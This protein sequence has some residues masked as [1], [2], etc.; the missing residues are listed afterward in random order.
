MAW[1]ITSSNIIVDVD[2]VFR[3]ESQIG[4][5]IELSE[6]LIK[7]LRQMKYYG[8]EPQH[9]QGLN[10]AE[11]FPCIRFL[12]TKVLETREETGDLVRRFSE[13]Q[14]KKNYELP[15]DS[16][17]REDKNNAI[18]YLDSVAEDYKPKRKF[19]QAGVGERD[20]ES[21]RVQATILEYG[22]QQK[23]TVVSAQEHDN[24]EAKERAAAIAE[25]LKESGITL[26]DIEAEEA[27]ISEIMRNLGKV[28]G[29]A[30]KVSSST[31]SNIVGQQA[32]QISS[33]HQ[34]YQEQIKSLG[35][36]DM[37]EAKLIAEESHRREIAK[38][39]KTLNILQGKFATVE[40]EHDK[41]SATVERAQAKL[42]KKEAHNERVIEETD[43]LHE[44]ETDEN[45]EI[46]TKLR[47]YVAL[48]KKLD[49][50]RDDFKANCKR[51]LKELKAAIAEMEEEGD[52]DEDDERW[53]KVKETYEKESTKLRKAKQLLNKKN[54]DIARIQRKI[55]EIPSRA[56]L[57]Q[58]EKR[59]L[60]L[61][62]Q[63]TA[64]LS[65]TKKYYSSYNTLE[66]SK[67][68]ISKEL[69]LLSSI[70]DNVREISSKTGREK[71]GEQIEG[72]NDGVS[73]S[74]LKVKE[75]ESGQI[76]QKESL[77]EEYLALL[78]QQRRYFKAVKDFK[79]ECSKNELL[80]ERLNQ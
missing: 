7:A 23:Q 55:D 65:E 39:E 35:L 48:N 51:Q 58:Y 22:R 49:E 47:H 27:Q 69:S 77:N 80:L 38:L 37:Q 34:E 18:P 43:A 66:D 74:L 16:A 62:E 1:A 9:I 31:V 46:I 11:L 73:N 68:Y 32:S 79:E 17:A 5:K 52:E 15:S 57:I 42:A 71:F 67:T 8:L 64:T 33:A 10:F 21:K 56:E 28:E 44:L 61:F 24:E 26:E 78:D 13:A 60:E 12:V 19:R 36:S 30:G 50:Q 4:E 70:N 40:E 14:F 29:D 72:I 59:F 3:E 53:A 6:T 25:K 2:V 75:K 45:Q 41:L 76:L 63:V 20:E 54:R